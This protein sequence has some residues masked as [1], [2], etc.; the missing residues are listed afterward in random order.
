MIIHKF[1]QQD[2]HKHFSLEK[3][4]ERIEKRTAYVSND[5]DWLSLFIPYVIAKIDFPDFSP[6]TYTLY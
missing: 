1:L 6:L 2:M 4:Y 5:V 3:S